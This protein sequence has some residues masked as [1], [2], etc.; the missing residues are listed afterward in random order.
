MKCWGHGCGRCQKAD[1][2]QHKQTCVETISNEARTAR[3]VDSV[4]SMYAK[5][6]GGDFAGVVAL[7]KQAEKDLA[8]VRDLD[9]LGVKKSILDLMGLA[10]SRLPDFPEAVRYYKRLAAY[11]ETLGLFTQQGDALMNIGRV[12]MNMGNT[13]EAY[14]MYE[15]AR[16]IGVRGG[17]F[18][19]ES[20]SCEGLSGLARREE[21]TAEALEF[22]Q[23]AVIAAECMQDDEHGKQTSGAAGV[24]A[25]I[26][27]SDIVSPLFDEALIHRYGDL[28]R[29]LE[30]KCNSED[31]V[32]VHE[33]WAMRHLAM[34]RTRECLDECREIVALAAN[35][36]LAQMIDVQQMAEHAVE[37]IQMLGGADVPA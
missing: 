25:V 21:R 12:N 16:D 17:Y 6:D 18:S 2:R 1:W 3:L 9:D 27:C 26:M 20:S 24:L 19:L 22:A 8:L 33:L 7:G 13:A 30:G 11:A 31:H 4:S 34:D 36:R 37:M 10:F 14:S 29:V 5:R 15:K 23:Q 35:P 28:A 32:K